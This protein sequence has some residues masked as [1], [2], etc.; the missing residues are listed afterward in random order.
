[1]KKKPNT[2]A[3]P[4]CIH[5]VPPLR[6]TCFILVPPFLGNLLFYLAAKFFGGGLVLMDLLDKPSWEPGKVVL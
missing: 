1:M 5:R 4:V 3:L 2:P 6:P